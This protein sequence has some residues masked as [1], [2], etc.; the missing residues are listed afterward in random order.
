MRKKNK[1]LITLFFLSQKKS[2]QAKRNTKTQN[3]NELSHN[4]WNKGT[5]AEN[6]IISYCCYLLIAVAI[7]NRTTKFVSVWMTLKEWRI[8]TLVNRKWS[9]AARDNKDVV[10]CVGTLDTHI[11][12]F[13]KSISIMY[14]LSHFLW[15]H[16]NLYADTL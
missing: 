8:N 5:I 15:S 1:F 3:M 2:A 16:S 9:N 12:T 14:Q 6:P 7:L 4:L 10:H 11:H 13:F